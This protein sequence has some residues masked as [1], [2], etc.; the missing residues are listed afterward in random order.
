MNTG[1]RGD[2][3]TESRRVLLAPAQAHAQ[4]LASFHEA[5]TVRSLCPSIQLDLGSS[6]S[7]R[8]ASRDTNEH[9]NLGHDRHEGLRRPLAIWAFAW[10]QGAFLSQSHIRNLI[11]ERVTRPNKST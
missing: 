4:K 8:H 2:P 1:V 6:E 7:Y 11:P 3:P 10:S 5:G 9:H